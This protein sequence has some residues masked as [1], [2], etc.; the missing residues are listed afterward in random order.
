[1]ND[2]ISLSLI[3]TQIRAIQAEQRTIRGDGKLTRST[4]NDMLTVLVDQI[5]NFEDLVATKLDEI[6][7]RLPPLA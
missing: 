2:T 4:L 5:A 7:V 3:G 6:L 1:M